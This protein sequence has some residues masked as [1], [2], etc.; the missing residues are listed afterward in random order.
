MEGGNLPPSFSRLRI[1]A[2]HILDVALGI[3][4]VGRRGND[5]GDDKPPL[6]VVDDAANF[7]PLE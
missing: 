6:I 4:R 7:L 1:T 5:I 2:T 3:D